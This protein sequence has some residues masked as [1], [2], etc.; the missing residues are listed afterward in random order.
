MQCTGCTAASSPLLTCRLDG[1]G[2]VHAAA[3]LPR[4]GVEVWQPLVLAEALQEAILPSDT[5]CSQWL[6][7]LYRGHLEDSL[8]LQPPS[9]G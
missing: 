8:V 9:G 2:D 1:Q 5:Y 6:I 3:D 7:W 4:K